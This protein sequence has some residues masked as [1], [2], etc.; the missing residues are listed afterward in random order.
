MKN[1][2]IALLC[3]VLIIGGVGVWYYTKFTQYAPKQYVTDTTTG[4]VT[5]NTE[6]NTTSTTTPTFTL[7]DVATHKDATSCYTAI[8][9]SVYDVTMWVNMH[10]GGPAKILSI[11]GI[12]GTD[13]FMN[14]HHGK[15]K[16][17]TILGRFKIGTLTQ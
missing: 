3:T 14:Q 11:C 16:F 15:P 10:P 1:T 6:T 13:A 9:G 4:S 8:S 5:T 12:D 17:M 2:T 7:A